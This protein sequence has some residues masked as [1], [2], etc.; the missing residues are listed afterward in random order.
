MRKIQKGSHYSLQTNSK[1]K[2]KG[3]TPAYVTSC[4][5]SSCC[6]SLALQQS[7]PGGWGH[8]HFENSFISVHIRHYIRARLFYFF[9][10][11]CFLIHD[12]LSSCFSVPYIGRNRISSVLCLGRIFQDF[13]ADNRIIN[14]WKHSELRIKPVSCPAEGRFQ[15]QSC[16]HCS[17]AQLYPV[18][19]WEGSWA[20]LAEV[21]QP[22]WGWSQDTSHVH[23][24]FLHF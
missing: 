1:K 14:R 13:R 9:F 4:K 19:C 24:L 10:F 20:G 21:S 11:V 8:Y 23:F 3:K 6:S 2:E 5:G 15:Q 22:F 7:R 16:G 18:V 17:T 12:L